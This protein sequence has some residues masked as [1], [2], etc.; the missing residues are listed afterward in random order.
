M[1]SGTLLSGA[2]I[3][4]VE[5]DFIIALDLQDTL[6]AV[7]AEVVGPAHDLREALALAQRESLT[8]ALV[9]NCLG[10]DSSGAIARQLSERRIPFV[11]YTGLSHPN[12]VQKEFPGVVVIQKPAESSAIVAALAKLA[13]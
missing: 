6:T 5:D 8:C 3:L 4:L 10:K 2:R 7:G 11:L 1:N 12:E 13:H 9:D